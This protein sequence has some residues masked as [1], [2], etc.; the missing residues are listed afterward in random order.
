MLHGAGAVALVVL[1]VLLVRVV[2]EEVAEAVEA[3][4]FVTSMDF[5]DAF[6]FDFY[7]FNSLM[8]SERRPCIKRPVNSSK[9]L[10]RL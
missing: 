2:E 9:I 4:D 6:V 1:A 5:C 8:Q 10:H 3:G 7:T